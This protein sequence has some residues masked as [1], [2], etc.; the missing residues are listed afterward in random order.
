LQPLAVQGV[1]EPAAPVCTSVC[2]SE[3][4]SAHGGAADAAIADPDLAAV[5]E[6]WGRL[7]DAIRAG[8]LALVKAAGG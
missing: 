3:A 1:T 7:P 4:E 6:A 8:I 5:V 2:T